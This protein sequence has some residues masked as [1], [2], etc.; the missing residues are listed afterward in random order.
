MDGDSRHAVTLGVARKPK[1]F[2]VHPK[3]SMPNVLVGIDAFDHVIVNRLNG[4]N[5]TRI[6]RLFRTRI[7]FD[8]RL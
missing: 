2:L 3:R 1:G 7:A 6:D 4:V 5:G 8:A